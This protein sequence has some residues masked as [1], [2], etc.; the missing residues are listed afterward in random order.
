[1]KRIIALIICLVLM[2]CAV[3]GL[4]E[5]AVVLDVLWSGD[6]IQ[7]A[8]I[9]S[10]LDAYTAKHPNVTFNIIETVYEDSNA[11]IQT[12]LAGGEPPA[13]ARVSDTQVGLYKP[14]ALDLTD[15]V[16]GTEKFTSEYMSNL[17]SSLFTYNDRVVAVPLYVTHNGL[18]V[19]KD[20]FEQA[21]VAYPT[22]E[23]DIW[24]WDEFLAALNTV[25]EKTG[26]E[27]GLLW[28]VSVHRWATMLYQ[29]G[30]RIFSDDRTSVV[31]NTEYREQSIEALQCFVDMHQSGLMPT[32]VWVGGGSAN[33]IW[34]AGEAAAFWCGTWGIMNFM[35]V[36]DFEYD[37]AYTP[38][39]VQRSSVIGGH[40]TMGFKDCKY[41]EIAADVLAFMHSKEGDNIYCHDTY[42]LSYR[43]DSADL[44]WDKATD[45]L[46]RSRNELDNTPF[47]SVND[48]M[49]ADVTPTLMADCKPIIQAAIAGEMTVEEAI[50]EFAV[51]AQ[52]ALDVYWSSK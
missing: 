10:V 36:V 19:N 6:A 38:V 51:V 14:Y 48:W 27:Y 35:N 32:S 25:K 44:G 50:D 7:M 31:M 30:G 20:L 40:Y 42:S 43:A 26:C 47:E 5:E 4:A 34:Y 1:M 13:I 21:G 41:P 12:M 23:E 24:T 37:I 2:L 29:Y 49:F 18:V 8:A 28:D 39:K 52:D 33:D 15:Y 11:K 16:G 17:D 22:A 46:L 3:I 9:E 45:M